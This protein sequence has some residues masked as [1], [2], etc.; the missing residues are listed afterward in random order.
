MSHGGRPADF[1]GIALPS[2]AP[3]HDRM[4]MEAPIDAL[5]V[6][7]GDPGEICEVV[8]EGD[9]CVLSQLFVF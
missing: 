5:P 4:V 2:L 6:I 8:L 3:H 1:R 9:R 7:P